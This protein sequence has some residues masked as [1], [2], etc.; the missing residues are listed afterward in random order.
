MAEHSRTLFIACGAL[1]RERISRARFEFSSSQRSPRTNKSTLSWR[2]C[3]GPGR[4]PAS[5]VC[6]AHP[7]L[8][9]AARHIVHEIGRDDVHFGLVGGGIYL[10]VRWRK[11]PRNAPLS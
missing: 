9:R 7:Y 11:T 3:A 5:D 1:A 10:F 6:D 8:L 2:R 4:P